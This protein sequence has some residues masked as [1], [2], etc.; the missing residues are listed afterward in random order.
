LKA[1]APL[2]NLQTLHLSDTSVANAGM[3]EVA[4]L[5]Q[6]RELNL[7]VTG[8]GN[9]WLLELTKLKNLELLYI[10]E[11]N[12]TK[13]GVKKLKAALP[14]CKVSYKRFI[15][16]MASLPYRES[17]KLL[18]HHPGSIRRTTFEEKCLFQPGSRSQRPT[19]LVCNGAKQGGAARFPCVFLVHPEAG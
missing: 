19:R 8:V 7:A 17:G 16:C 10:S 18:A 13:D 12:A 11:S 6:L 9:A 1:L 14:R 15:E 2:K 4:K 5:K 3:K